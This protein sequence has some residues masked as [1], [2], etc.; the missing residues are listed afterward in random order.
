MVLKRPNKYKIIRQRR[1]FENIFIKI[2]FI[3]QFII[4]QSFRKHHLLRSREERDYKKRQLT[5]QTYIY[6]L[7]F[8]LVSETLFVRSCN[9]RKFDLSCSIEINHFEKLS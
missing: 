4:E 6:N 1:N 9:T 7:I 5:I 8:A 2:S 3:I